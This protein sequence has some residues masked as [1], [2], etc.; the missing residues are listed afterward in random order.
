MSAASSTVIRTA[1][2]DLL[3]EMLGVTSMH[4][5]VLVDARVW[6]R[7]R[8]DGDASKKDVPVSMSNLADVRWNALS[9]TDNLILDERDTAAAELGK[10]VAAGGSAI[11]D[12]TN[13]G[14]GGDARAVAII[15]A[16][17]NLNLIV[18]CGFY[19]HGSHPSWVC[20]ATVDD[21]EAAIER[22]VSEGVNGS[23]V[24]PG[25]IG[26]IGMSAPPQE[27]ERRVLKAG[28]RVAARYAMS[29]HIHVDNSGEY[30]LQHIED[31]C[32]EGLTVDRIVCG[33]MDERLNA[34]YHRAILAEGACIAFD[35]FGSELYFSGLFTHP[36]D[37]DR[38]RHL[39]QLI[40]DGFA[41]RIVLGHDVFVKA[42]WHKF[43][44]N[45]SDHL[46]RRAL[47]TLTMD[48]G[49]DR[50]TVD[51]L[52]LH[53]PRRLLACTPQSLEARTAAID[54]ASR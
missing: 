14:L 25:V 5:H 6:Y 47:P 42:H 34:P 15:A 49:I 9:F 26:E 31:C 29:L 8:S 11:V 48:F 43:G 13:V 21:L 3:P 37:E 39:A 22:Q 17:E 36:K 45:G 54:Q 7:T 16:A 1:A 27:C 2:G 28:A 30:A 12:M 10:F 35:T 20:E 23:G 24:L 38:L 53:N 33:H 52:V 40:Q 19:V 41:D 4:E 18:G 46:L 51:R 44:G 32:S 50:E